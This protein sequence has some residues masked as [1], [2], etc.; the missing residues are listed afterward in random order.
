MP[1]G[2]ASVANEENILDMI[3][4]TVDTG[5]IGG[6]PAGGPSFGAVANAQAIID[7]PYQFDFYDGGGLDQAFL[8][9][10]ALYRPG[11]SCSSH[12]T[13]HTK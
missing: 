4:L 6:I 3:T 7:Q 5:G 13:Q 1:E 9:V 10:N 12:R 2:V 8:S 11:N